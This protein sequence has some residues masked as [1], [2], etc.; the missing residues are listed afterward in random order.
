MGIADSI[1]F[2]LVP[3]H[4]SNKNKFICGLTVR[5]LSNVALLRGKYVYWKDKKHT[6]QHCIL[7]LNF[8]LKKRECNASCM[9][10]RTNWQRYSNNC[11]D[12]HRQVILG[13]S[14]LFQTHKKQYEHTNMYNS[15]KKKTWYNIIN[16]SFRNL[17]VFC[18]KIKL[19]QR[20]HFYVA[21]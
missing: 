14:L 13:K 4:T 1:Q 15:Y 11:Q 20:K 8:S 7:L 18:W 12:D 3:F 10:A 6:F 16:N 17:F 19:Q 2:P 21:R 9:C 5:S